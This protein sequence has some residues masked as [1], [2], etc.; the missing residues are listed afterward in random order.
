MTYHSV[1]RWA[2]GYE[3]G[4]R[5]WQMVPRDMRLGDEL[6]LPWEE[7]YFTIL[8]LIRVEKSG[9]HIRA[10]LSKNRYSILNRE[11]VYEIKRYEWNEDRSGL[12]APVEKDEA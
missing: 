6:W 12:P 2:D 5:I 4:Y 11:T 9:V 10:R 1:A 7:Q 3:Q 8:G